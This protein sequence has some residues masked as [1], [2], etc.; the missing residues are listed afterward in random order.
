MCY[1]QTFD[2]PFWLNLIKILF[3]LPQAKVL[4]KGVF[5]TKKDL[6]E[7]VLAYIAR[8]NHEGRPF[9]RTK[10]AHATL[11]SWTKLTRR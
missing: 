11:R 6:V 2:C 7:K 3:N 1:C 10:A 9:L 5:P 4:R 8:L